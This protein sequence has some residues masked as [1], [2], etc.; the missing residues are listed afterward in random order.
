MPLTVFKKVFFL[1]LPGL[2][3]DNKYKGLNINIFTAFLCEKKPVRFYEIK[4]NFRKSTL[5][6]IAI[7]TEINY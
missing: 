1:I 6:V 2:Y 3:T 5:F 7:S 4:F